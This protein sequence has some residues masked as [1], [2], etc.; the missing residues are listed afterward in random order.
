MFEYMGL[1]A[2]Q[3]VY[4]SSQYDELRDTVDL[5]GLSKDTMAQKAS[6]LYALVSSLGVIAD[7]DYDETKY[8]RRLI[9]TTLMAL[10][11]EYAASAQTPQPHDVLDQA[12][13]CIA[14]VVSVMEAYPNNLWKY[15]VY[16]LR[17]ALANVTEAYIQPLLKNAKG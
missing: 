10:A 13:H 2:P 3:D 14:A 9:R 12:M 11:E 1:S 7:T 5:V 15:R 6:R 17:I 16:M 8:V 4:H